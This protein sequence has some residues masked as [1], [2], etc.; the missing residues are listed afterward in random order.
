M[1]GLVPVVGFF[2]STSFFNRHVLAWNSI[3]AC[4]AMKGPETQSVIALSFPCPSRYENANV[5]EVHT[6]SWRVHS[7]P[8]TCV[9]SCVSI[10]LFRYTHICIYIYTHRDTCREM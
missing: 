2:S 9:N 10:Q 6:E 4:A 3:G 5:A 7:V 8:M 1:F